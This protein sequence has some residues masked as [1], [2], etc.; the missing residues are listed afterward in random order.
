[1]ADAG[2]QDR[3]STTGPYVVGVGTSAGGLGALRTLFGSMP[4][5]PGV[6]CVVVVHLSPEHDSRMVELLQPYTAMRVQQ[7]TQT[8]P[9]EPNRI[10]VIPPN[11]NLDTI[12]TH[13]R[14]S[15]L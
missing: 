7:V 13:L 12:D 14:L 2:E 1:M 15:E 9:I 4:A 3:M 5:S 11:A 10:Y 8:V 6:A